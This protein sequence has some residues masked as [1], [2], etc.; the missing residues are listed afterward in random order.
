VKE[1][2]GLDPVGMVAGIAQKNYQRWKA[3]QE[4]IFRN[5]ASSRQDEED[6]PASGSRG[7]KR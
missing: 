7:S 6:K 3:L 2:V 1:V 5:F 4:E